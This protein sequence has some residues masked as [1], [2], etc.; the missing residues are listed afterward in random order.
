MGKY[1]NPVTFITLSLDIN[2]LPSK[3]YIIHRFVSPQKKGKGR[4]RARNE[5]RE[6]Q[7]RNPPP[8]SAPAPI[9]HTP[10]VGT[11]TPSSS[12][13]TISPDAMKTIADA[14]LRAEE[15]DGATLNCVAVSE[16]CFKLGR[17][18]VPPSIALA[19]NGISQP[20]PGIPYSH[21]N[22]P[23]HWNKVT[24][25]TSDPKAIRAFLSGGWREVPAAECWW[26]HALAGPVE[27]TRK[28]N[29]E[30]VDGLRRS[31]EGAKALY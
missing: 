12:Q 30:L 6:S 8:N 27:A 26:E 13:T 16:V 18:T 4:G 14:R 2:T 29:L 25:L 1:S 3:L 5:D 28:A 31:M 23:P 17:I 9:L 22:P 20:S 11:D 15:P 21:K 24:E 7:P 10:A 19:L